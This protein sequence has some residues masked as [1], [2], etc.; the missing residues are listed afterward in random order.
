MG[1]D[2]SSET[3]ETFEYKTMTRNF[4]E[5]KNN[6]KNYVLKI[7]H[8]ELDSDISN[9][10][11]YINDFTENGINNLSEQMERKSAIVKQ[12]K[13][14]VINNC[15]STI[16]MKENCDE[17]NKVLIDESET[18]Q[19]DINNLHTLLLKHESDNTDTYNLDILKY[20][21]FGKRDVKSMSQLTENF[22]EYVDQS[23]LIE[24]TEDIMTY[25]EKEKNME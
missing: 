4:A 3:N 7:A 23:C 9:N 25:E 17:K 24:T 16:D 11:E 6:N 13:F 22:Q 21:Q 10:E 20:V 14:D 1:E 18:H 5:K 15:T 19:E 12:D 2:Y 8:E